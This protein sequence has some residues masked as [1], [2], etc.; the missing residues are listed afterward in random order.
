M[1]KLIS[2]IILIASVFLSGETDAFAVNQRRF[3]RRLPE[4]TK[5]CAVEQSEDS[6]L[7]SFSNGKI[8]LLPQKSCSY[9]TV[10]PEGYWQVNGTPT[11]YKFASE[12]CMTVAPDGRWLLDG[13]P[14]GE[15]IAATEKQKGCYVSNIVA[16]ARR[17]KI[18]FTDGKSRVFEKK[19]E[20]GM[21]VEKTIG[22][23]YIYMGRKGSQDW[24]RYQFF[25]R[26]KEYNKP[27]AYPNHLDNWGLGLPARF[28]NTEFGFSFPEDAE[29]FIGGEAEAAVQVD[30]PNGKMV[31]TG[32][33]HHGWENILKDDSGKRRIVIKIDGAEVQEAA[34]FDRRPAGR[35]EIEQHTRIAKAF[36]DPVADQYATI[37]KRWVIADGSVS[38]S[39]EYSFTSD[40]NINQAMFGMVCVRRLDQQDPDYKKKGADL[41]RGYVTNIAW[42][43]T[44]PLKMY[45][46]KEGWEKKDSEG[47]SKR[48][49][50]V[51]R[52]KDRQA[53][54]IEEYGE[55]GWTFAIEL[56]ESSDLEGGGFCIGTNKRNYNKIYFDICGKYKA[57]TGDKLF[58]TVRWEID[59][60]SDWAKF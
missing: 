39:N 33:V 29:L 18:N 23:I 38:I 49:Y 20:W 44:D 22:N 41:S 6:F 26:K 31:Y 4:G 13:E 27:A 46:L 43:D 1:K 28:K 25:H 42:K 35:I 16:T 8:L 55:K 17:V 5:I 12:E 10:S 51:F 9:V 59:N 36:G 50:D 30:S 53:R 3:F 34:C 48:S 52:K 15:R 56:L 57:S 47:F 11:I 21:Y 14:T 60:F 40:I 7:L 54:R 24:V 19:I 37:V 58:S 32:G 45:S 2:L